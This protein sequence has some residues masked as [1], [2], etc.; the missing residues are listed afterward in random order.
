MN[1]HALAWLRKTE[2]KKVCQ[3]PEKQRLRGTKTLLGK[4]R[5][6]QKYTSYN[7]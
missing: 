5:S 1:M 6:P 2:L 3:Y 7:N 4:Y